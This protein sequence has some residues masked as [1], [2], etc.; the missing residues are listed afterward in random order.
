MSDDKPRHIRW[1]DMEYEPVTDQIRRR[2]VTGER[3]M[4]AQVLSTKVA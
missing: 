4:I 2:L 1:D 3:A